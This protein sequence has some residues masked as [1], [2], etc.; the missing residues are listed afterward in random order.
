MQEFHPVPGQ[1][2]GRL[3]GGASAA[4]PEEVRCPRCDSANTKFC[5]YNNYNLSQP[6]HFCK[7]CRR[8]WTKGGLLRNVPVG[9]GCRKPKRPV[10]SVADVDRGGDG[11][12]YGHRDAKNARTAG[13][14]IGGGAGSSVTTTPAAA[15]ASNASSA[16]ATQP[17]SAGATV[18]SSVSFAA[19]G[20]ALSLPPPPAPMFAHQAAAFASLFAPPL[21][22][23]QA[24]PSFT[25]FSASAQPKAEEDVAPAPTPTEPPSSSS[26]TTD[27]SPFAARSS[28]GPA[29]AADWAPATALDAGMFDFASTIG[30]DTSYW[31]PTSWTDHDGTIYLP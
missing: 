7:A 19:A 4:A 27:I 13:S 11:G 31:N 10:S 15:P 28:A 2:A 30:G 16:T 12:G 9:G 29:E 25:S 20:D 23:P 14:C 5:Y 21:P 26:L 1:L 18:I 8:Y 17:S 22:P 6:R 3:F 24:L